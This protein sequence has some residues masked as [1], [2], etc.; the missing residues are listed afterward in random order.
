MISITRLCYSYDSILKPPEDGPIEPNNQIIRISGINRTSVAGSFVVSIW[1]RT[2][3]GDEKPQHAADEGQRQPQEVLIGYEPVFSRWYVPGC[4]NCN[5]SLL[6]TVHALWDQMVLK[7]K[8]ARIIVR[9]M[10]R[11]RDSARLE[12]LGPDRFGRYFGPLKH[13]QVQIDGG[14]KVQTINPTAV[15]KL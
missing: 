5:N 9:L 6:V 7:G 3:T 1:A 15:S 10:L 14:F 2:L 8:V 4:A 11:N 12:Y 13:L